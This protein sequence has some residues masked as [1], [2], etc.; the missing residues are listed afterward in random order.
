[1][2]SHRRNLWAAGYLI[3][4]SV[5]ASLAVAAQGSSSEAYRTW[6]D[7]TGKH[8]VEAAFVCFD[9]GKV[10]L[11]KKDGK[12]IAV[13]LARLSEPDQEFAKKQLAEPS[14]KPAGHPCLGSP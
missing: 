13:P 1:M 4:L 12:E 2:I 6:T 3:V 10:R 5:M 8:Q 9:G 14:Q 11:K 7:S